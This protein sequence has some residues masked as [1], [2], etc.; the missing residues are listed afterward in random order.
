[1]A[2][3]SSPWAS[4]VDPE[5]PRQEYPRPSLVRE[6]WLCLNGRW[7]FAIREEGEA[8]GGF[9]GRIVV[10]FPVESALSEVQRPLGPRKVLWYRRA[11]SLPDEFRGERL[12]LHVEAADWEA[13]VYV[14]GRMAGSHRGGYAPFS[15]DI[16]DFLAS[17]SEQELVL[18]IRD[19]SD[20]GVQCRGKQSLRPQGIWYTASSGIWGT[21]WLEPVPAARIERILAHVPPGAA[22]EDGGLLVKAR[23]ALPSG[24]RS[25]HRLRVAA[26]SG[27]EPPREGRGLGRGW[28]YRG[29]AGRTRGSSLVA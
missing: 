2:T 26:K 1:M 13:R 18:E 17:G 3:L 20:A 5:R 29:R 24:D 10:P 16:T 14:N 9:D 28:D 12:L 19:P 7:D 15:F 4:S 27:G 11:F 21:I 22:A 8:P 23:L 6:R 25:T